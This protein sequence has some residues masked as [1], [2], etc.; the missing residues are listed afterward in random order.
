MQ[1]KFENPP[2]NELVIATY[3]NPP[4]VDLR[5]EH[6]G[7]FWSSV[8]DEYPQIRQQAPL[9]VVFESPNEIFPLPRFWLISKDDTT[10]I[11][12]QKNAFLFNWRKRA[13]AYPHYANVKSEFDRIFAIFSDFLKT[14]VTK[15]DIEIEVCELT[16]IN[17]VEECE[18]WKSIA[19]VT[20]IFPTLKLIE[21]GVDNLATD[22]LSNVT[23]Y[24]ID[25]RLNLQLTIQTGHP[26]DRPESSQLKFEFRATSNMEKG[27]KADADRWFDHAHNVIGNCFMTTTNQEI[28]R[29][30]WKPM[31]QN[32]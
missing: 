8:R 26:S 1:L 13:D 12:L 32:G 6:I 16:Y 2:I 5:A 11:Q 10:V 7:I 4:I 9:G 31:E 19:D 14:E 27:S 20:S 25:E 22:S 23:S 30:F 24:R 29:K 18:Y 21:I 15:R 3:F 17:L 28:Q